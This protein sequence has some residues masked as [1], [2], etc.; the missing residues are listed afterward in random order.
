MHASSCYQ[1]YY[2]LGHHVLL[3]LLGV[4]CCKIIDFF[5]F[6][7]V[8]ILGFFGDLLMRQAWEVGG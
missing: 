7:Q 6:L 3:Y 1:V 2:Y 8:F 4:P 5:L